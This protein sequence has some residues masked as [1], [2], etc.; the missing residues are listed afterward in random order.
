M[1]KNDCFTT[2]YIQK[3][4][5]RVSQR[6]SDDMKE[7]NIRRKNDK[8]TCD[9]GSVIPKHTMTRHINTQKHTKWKCDQEIR[10]VVIC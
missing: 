7:W 3:L 5:R 6:V 1:N 8:F 10:N 4:K 9:C 2:P